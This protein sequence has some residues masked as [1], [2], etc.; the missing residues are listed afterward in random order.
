MLI[1]AFVDRIAGLLPRQL[2]RHATTRRIEVL[3]EF[4][5]FGLVGILGFACDTIVVYG[6]RGTLGLYGAGLV[7]YL[8]AATLTW[9]LNRAWTFKGRGNGRAHRQW[10]LFLLANLGGFILNRG[11]YVLLVTFV[12]ICAREPIFAVFAGMLAGMM[13]NF[14]LSRSL[15]FR[16]VEPI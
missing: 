2:Q 15:V 5:R 4:C 6:L 11:T 8:F 16:K 14:T 10:A 13:S 3:A 9:A 12:A 7:S 1:R